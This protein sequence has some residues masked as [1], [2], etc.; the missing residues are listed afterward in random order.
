M[1]VG[2]TAS[3][4]SILLPVGIDLLGMSQNINFDISLLQTL[5]TKN[6]VSSSEKISL[7]VYR[8]CVQ[9]I[10]DDLDTFSADLDL[11]VDPTL[12]TVDPMPVLRS[13]YSNRKFALYDKKTNPLRRKL[14]YQKVVR[15]TQLKR[16][17]QAN[18]S[19]LKK[20]RLNNGPI[21]RAKEEKKSSGTSIGNFLFKLLF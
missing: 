13:Y 6:L 3:L 2:S 14:R 18:K 15:R 4:V 7:Y 17:N 20:E 19:E 1:A 9:V 16:A 11:V 10:P 8:D 5:P 12:P 21:K